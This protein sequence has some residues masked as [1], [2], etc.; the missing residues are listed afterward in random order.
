[1]KSRL[2][3]LLIGVLFQLG[4]LITAQ[5]SDCGTTYDPNHPPRQLETIQTGG[6]YVTGEGVLRVLVVFVQFPN[7]TEQNSEWPIGQPPSYFQTFIDSTT[8]QNSSLYMNITNF[9]RQMSSNHLLLTGKAYHMIARNNSGTYGGNRDMLHREILQR[10]DSVISFAEYDNWMEFT[11]FY[12]QQVKPMNVVVQMPLVICNRATSGV[13]PGC[14]RSPDIRTAC[15]GPA[16]W[17]ENVARRY[18]FF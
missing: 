18:D 6:L 3:Y 13:A 1:M 9:Y 7:E 10:L 15:V 12:G 11:P 2:L 14:K 5:E 8:T 16:P 4:S 17:F